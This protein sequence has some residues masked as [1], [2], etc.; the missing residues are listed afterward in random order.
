MASQ[1]ESFSGLDITRLQRSQLGA[2]I[3]QHDALQAHRC[4]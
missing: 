2:Q 4:P 3:M 1:D